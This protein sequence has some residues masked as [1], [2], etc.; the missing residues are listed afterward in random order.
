MTLYDI[1]EIKKIM[2]VEDKKLC[3]KCINILLNYAWNY[4][5]INKTKTDR[6]LDNLIEKYKGA[7]NEK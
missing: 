2:N 1:I 3:S 4:F 6:I 5:H 7:S